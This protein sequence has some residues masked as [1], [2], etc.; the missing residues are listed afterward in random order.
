MGD[1]GGVGWGAR[2]RRHNQSRDS[3]MLQQTVQDEPASVRTG[4]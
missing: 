3:W 4:L 2:W 1:D